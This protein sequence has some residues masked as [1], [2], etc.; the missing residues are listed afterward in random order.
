MET[1]GAS[2]EF[3]LEGEI[4]WEVASEGVKR[5]IMLAVITKNVI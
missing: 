2:K 4:P 5:K 3:L 1:F